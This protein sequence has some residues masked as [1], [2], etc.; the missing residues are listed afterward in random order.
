MARAR[1]YE[2]N[3]SAWRGGEVCLPRALEPKHGS[4]TTLSGQHQGQDKI[5]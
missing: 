2:K 1:R 3:P 5:G 4:N